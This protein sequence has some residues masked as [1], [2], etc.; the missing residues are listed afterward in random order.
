MKEDKHSIFA[1]IACIAIVVI[2]VATIVEGHNVFEKFK[3]DVFGEENSIEYNSGE[4][5]P[6]ETETKINTSGEVKSGINGRIEA[7]GYDESEI[8]YKSYDGVKNVQNF[9][10]TNLKVGKINGSRSLLLADTKNN[11]KEFQKSIKVR[12]SVIDENDEVKET[13]SAIINELAGLESGKFKAQVLSDITYAKDFKI[14][15]VNEWFETLNYWN[16]VC[17][18]KWKAKKWKNKNK[19]KKQKVKN[20]KE[21]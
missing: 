20:K 18:L 8:S 14:E 1:V 17:R 3:A 19:K 6:N 16:E 12:I 7:D 11:T 9:E 13:F 2:I 15:V 10:L 21:R 5:N 4:V